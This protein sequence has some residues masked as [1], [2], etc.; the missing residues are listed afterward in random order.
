MTTLTETQ[1]DEERTTLIPLDNLPTLTDKVDRLNQRAEKLGVDPMRLLVIETVDRETVN[2]Y[3]GLTHRE[4]FARVDIEGESPVLG[5][6]SLVSRVTLADNGEALTLTV[7]G[8]TCPPE[9]RDVDMARCDHCKASR[10]RKDVFVLLHEDGQ[11]I[12]VGRQ[13]LADHLGHVSAE[14]MLMLATWV[15]D[16][17][18]ECRDASERGWG[19]TEPTIDTLDFITA[20]ALVCRRIGWTSRAKARLDET[21]RVQATSS[22]AWSLCT[23]PG[24][25]DAERR[26]WRKWVEENDLHVSDSDR[27]DAE[28][29]LKW[30]RAIA[31]GCGNEYLY[32]LGVAARQDAVTFRTSGL[33]ASA[34]SAHQRVLDEAVVAVERVEAG[35]K[36]KHIG[37]VGERRRFNDLA[38]V[39]LKTFDGDYGPST[40]CRFDD[41]DGNVVIWWATGTAPEW[42]DDEGVFDVVGRVKAHEDYNGTPQTVLTRV[43]PAT[44]GDK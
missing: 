31:P 9:F 36:Q 44:D 37:E 39:S 18:D 23:G 7:P 8:Q 42:L 38:C 32:N 25:S 22:H 35:K 16:L 4:R 26:H 2:E 17:R 30:A 27:A 12:Q 24:N 15:R 11:H 20:T 33:V 6:W 21:G 41:L 14:S 19:G 34:I 40:L 10:H 28:A 43:R 13:C 29:A 5:G 3:T 1:T